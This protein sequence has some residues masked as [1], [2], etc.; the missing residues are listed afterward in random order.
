[1]NCPYRIYGLASASA[2]ITYIQKEQHVIYP[3]NS[4]KV[5]YKEPEDTAVIDIDSADRLEL[6][7]CCNHE[8]RPITLLS[9]LDRC[10]TG[11]GT[12]MLRATILQP[13]C[14]EDVIQARLDCVQEIRDNA[15]FRI[16]LKVIYSTLKQSLY[17]L[18]KFTIIRF[19]T[20]LY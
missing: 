4:I 11:V 12:K 18:D 9:M 17:V 19:L 14:V 3:D 2:L 15:V 6:V 20:R 10:V 7:C 16:K 1:M 5:E 13:Q 8:A